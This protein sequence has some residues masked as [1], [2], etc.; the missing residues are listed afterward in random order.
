MA[1]DNNNNDNGDER[2]EIEKAIAALREEALPGLLAAYDKTG[3]V[4]VLTMA[5][6]VA[7]AWRGSGFTTDQWR[8]LINIIDAPETTP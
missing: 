6:I 5:F 2:R 8:A 1:G 4:S 3:P 7:D